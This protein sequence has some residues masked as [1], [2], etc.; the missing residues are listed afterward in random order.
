[1]PNSSEERMSHVAVVWYVSIDV[2]TV[3]VVLV[4]GPS[5]RRCSVARNVNLTTHARA[6]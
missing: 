3:D 4:A 1:M 5:S 6:M 2:S